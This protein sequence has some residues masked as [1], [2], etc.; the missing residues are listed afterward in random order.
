[1][2]AITTRESR[3]IARFWSQ[4]K[5]DDQ[6]KMWTNIKAAQTIAEIIDTIMG[7]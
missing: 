5:L 6:N 4:S 1:M 7:M 2:P 3:I